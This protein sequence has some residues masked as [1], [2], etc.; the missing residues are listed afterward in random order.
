MNG[1]RFRKRLFASRQMGSRWIQ[2]GEI[3]QRTQV[4]ILE[5][6]KLY[7]GYL[8]IFSPSNVRRNKRA[9]TQLSF[10]NPLK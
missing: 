10:E 1:I 6:D 9:L 5:I 4:K 2:A 7:F 3:R 8:L